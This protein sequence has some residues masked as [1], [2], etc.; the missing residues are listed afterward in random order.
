MVRAR[1]GGD[2]VVLPGVVGH[3]GTGYGHI[4]EGT[5]C[6]GIFVGGHVWGL[7]AGIGVKE[8]FSYD[9]G[10]EIYLDWGGVKMGW[11]ES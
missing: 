10:F 11:F 7:R 1:D 5:A 3:S 6:V 8:E 2:G 9:L 4:G